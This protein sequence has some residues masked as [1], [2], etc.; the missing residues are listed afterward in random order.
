MELIIF[1]QLTRYLFFFLNRI[2]A[3]EILRFVIS[4]LN[5]FE[6]DNRVSSPVAENL[7]DITGVVIILR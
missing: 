2:E 4:G 1:H 7:I 6:F 5:I 3:I